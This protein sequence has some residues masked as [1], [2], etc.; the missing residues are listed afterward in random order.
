M[1]VDLLRN[2]LSRVCNT[3]SV[4]VPKLM[5]VESFE[6]VHQLVSTIRGTLSK[7]KNI[8]DVFTACFPG[9]SMTGAPKLRSVDILQSLEQ[10]VSRGPYSGSLGYFSLNGCMDMNIL[11]RSAVFTPGY[12]NDGQEN[13]NINNIDDLY[14]WDI[15]VGA[16]GAITILSDADD[17]WD[18]IILKSKAI[19]ESIQQW[20]N[21]SPSL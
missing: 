13:D 2:D 16:G 4:Q 18:E 7:D 21:S 12:K 11:I 1:I 5:Q 20:L 6:T 8:V 15:S 14:Q 9:G 17:E 3:G 19:K 10:N